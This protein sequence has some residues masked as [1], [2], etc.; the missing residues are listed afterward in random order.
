M[1]SSPSS[2]E[3]AGVEAAYD[4][5]QV[6]AQA[7]PQTEPPDSG[8]GSD[9]TPSELSV[10]LL[11]S[12]SAALERIERSIDERL[13]AADRN[14]SIIDRLHDEVQQ[15]R[16]RQDVRRVE[17]IL[18]ALIHIRDDCQTV[19]VRANNEEQ[20]PTRDEVVRSIDVLRMQ[21]EEVLYREGVDAFVPVVGE[22]FDAKRHQIVAVAST[23]DAEHDKTIT[24]VRQ[25]GFTHDGRILRPALVDVAKW[26]QQQLTESDSNRTAT[27]SDQP[28]QGQPKQGE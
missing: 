23:T 20:L 19:V 25:P 2:A 10:A 11:T 24:S 15:T 17:P 12:L 7:E 9:G 26:D 5:L 8:R 3:G 13:S 14:A 16:L 22:S 21:I 27:P 28:P 4:E 18:R 6:E 1:P